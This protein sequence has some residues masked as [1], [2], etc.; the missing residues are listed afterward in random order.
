VGKGDGGCSGTSNE[1]PSTSNSPADVAVGGDDAFIFRG[2]F[3][4]RNS[5][6]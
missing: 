2:K 3:T 6:L 1:S 4:Q 5:K